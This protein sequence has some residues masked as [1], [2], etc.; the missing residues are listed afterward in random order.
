[1]RA[2]G[3][4]LVRSG[5]E[6]RLGEWVGAVRGLGHATETGRGAIGRVPLPDGH[7]IVKHYRHGGWFRGLLGDLY[8]Q[9]PPRPWRELAA[10]EAARAAGILAPEVLAAIVAPLGRGAPLAWLY[11]GELV[12]RELP[13]RR[14]LGSALRAASG[15]GERRAWL[16]AAARAMRELHR[17]GVSHPDLSVGNFLVG[18]DP[19]APIAIIDFDRAAALGRRVGALGRWTARRR[20]ARSVA[21]LDLPGLDRA[22]VLAIVGSTDAPELA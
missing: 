5:H 20:L 11:R 4:S 18:D 10:T 1:V 6:T 19:G 14:S 15:A 3:A 12:T 17:A 16:E 13:G 2:D 7:A 22:S 21:K 8:W 9:W